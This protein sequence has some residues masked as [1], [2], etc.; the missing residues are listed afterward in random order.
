MPSKSPRAATTRRGQIDPARSNAQTPGKMSITPLATISGSRK[1]KLAA[2]TEPVA[3]TLA[4]SS[5]VG[6]TL[7]SLDTAF[8]AAE[9][10]TPAE[11]KKKQRKQQEEKRLRMTRKQPPKSFLEKL[12]RA[13]TQR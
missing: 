2:F 13:Q 8:Q 9:D 4:L 5:P 3:A 7:N 10:E 12:E 11:G 6:K 1:R